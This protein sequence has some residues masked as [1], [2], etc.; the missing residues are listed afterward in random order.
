MPPSAM[1]WHVDAGLVEVAH[2][3]GAGVGDGGGLRHADAEHA[4][5][6]AGVAGADADEHADRAGAHEVEGG[7]V[8]GAA[9]DDHRASRSW[10]MTFMRLSGSRFFETCSAE[11]TVPW[12]TSRSSSPASDG[13]G[14]SWSVR[15]G[16]TDAAAHDAGVADLG[17]CASRDQLGLD[18]LGVDLLHA[19][20]GLLVVEL[21]RSPRA[22]A[23]DPRSGST[24]PRG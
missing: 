14:S 1:T 15:C 13:V 17:G 11:T 4:A 3:G 2:A 19:P 8:A 16:V 23:P 5:G 18:R 7:L 22:A 10:R 9:A 21:R 12:M 6:R 20:G 24:G